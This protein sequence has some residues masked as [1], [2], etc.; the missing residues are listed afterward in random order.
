VKT[1]LRRIKN[2]LAPVGLRLSRVRTAGYLL[3][4]MAERN[5]G[6]RA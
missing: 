1:T 3:D 5:P 2:A 6:A 4:R